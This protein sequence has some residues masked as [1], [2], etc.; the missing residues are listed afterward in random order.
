MSTLPIVAVVGRPNVGKS[1]LVNRIVGGRSAVVEEMPGVTRD[2]RNFEADWAGRSFILIDTGGWERDP[3]SGISESIKEQAELALVGAD[4]VLFVVD[5]RVGSTPDDEA[6]VRLLRRTKVPVVLVAN[7]I[8]DAAHE[9]A[10]A[11]LWS[12][13]LGEPYGVSA[14]HGRGVGELLDRLVGLLPPTTQEHDGGGLPRLALIGRPNVGKSTLLNR[15]LGEERVI[16]SPTPGT[17]R[18]PIDVEAKIDGRPYILVDTAGIRRRPQISESA[19]FFAVERARRVLGESDAA[20]VLIDGIEGVTAADQRIIDEAIEAGVSLVILLNK[21]DR[22]QSSE[23][24]ED[25]TRSV[26]GKLGFVSW[27]PIMRGSALTGARL[28]RLGPMIEQGLE[29]RMRRIGTGELNRLISRWTA[30]HPPPVRKGRRP[31]IQYAVQA[32]VAPP[33][34]VLFVAGGEL[35]NDYLRFLENRLREE[36]DFAGTPIRIVTRTGK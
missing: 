19:D 13:G 18:D 28:G 36:V 32:G 5:A 31:R 27:A 15:L 30:A 3:E 12:L 4:V 7:K 1:S 8:D 34:F 10:L 6:V 33:T 20:V 14:L 2:R 9:S 35:G 17:T 16:V 24:R 26:E 23:Q 21:W 25:A 29:A 11:D 22:A